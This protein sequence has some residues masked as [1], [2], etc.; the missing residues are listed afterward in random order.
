MKI[1]GI[2]GGIADSL[3][4]IEINNS[5]RSIKRKD[6][7]LKILK[8]Q[9]YINDK[10]SNINSLLPLIVSHSNKNSFLTFILSL[11]LS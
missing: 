2:G 3:G 11:Q 4:F 8:E 5:S 9:K 1:N 7:V 10:E 6:L